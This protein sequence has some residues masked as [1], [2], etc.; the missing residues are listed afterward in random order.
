MIQIDEESL[1]R[2]QGLRDQVEQILALAQ[3]LGAQDK[4]LVEQVFKHGLS[5]T[6]VARL[7]GQ[8]PRTVQKRVKNLVEHMQSPLFRF[9]VV[10]PE[11]LSPGT[12]RVAEAVVLKRMSLRKAA[13]VLGL[14]LHQVRGQLIAA[15]A[16]AGV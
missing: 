10:S 8:R 14:R 11:S 7:L 2:R 15:R 9:L 13:V 4:L 3:H 5:V 6:D 1:R 16:V 12:R